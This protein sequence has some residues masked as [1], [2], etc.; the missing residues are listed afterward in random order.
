MHL[1]EKLAALHVP[2]GKLVEVRERTRFLWIVPFTRRHGWLSI[3]DRGDHWSVTW[4]RRSDAYDPVRDG[5]AIW[6]HVRKDTGERRHQLGGITGVWRIG[7]PR[8][9]RRMEYG[10]ERLF[11]RVHRLVDLAY[12]FHFTQPWISKPDLIPSVRG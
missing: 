9:L 5:E 1:G 7:L 12:I 6:I 3:E 11:Q 10:A 8:R 4:T 2:F